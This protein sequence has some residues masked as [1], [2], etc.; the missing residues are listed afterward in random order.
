M[1]L[2]HRRLTVP[3]HAS[4]FVDAAPVHDAVEPDRLVRFVRKGPR[5]LP[6]RLEVRLLEDVL[7]AIRLGD[8]SA[9]DAAEPTVV[10]VEEPLEPRPVARRGRAFLV[11]AKPVERVDDVASH[12]QRYT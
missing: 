2:E 12:S 1:Q 5:Q 3:A 11:P 7:Y 8:D 6:V 10:A 9:D 4:H